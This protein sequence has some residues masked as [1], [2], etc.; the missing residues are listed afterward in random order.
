[1]EGHLSTAQH[2]DSE[3]KLEGRT[4]NS[5]PINIV[6]TINASTYTVPA[7]MNYYNSLAQQK[8]IPV[9]QPRVYLKPVHTH[10]P[11]PD[12]R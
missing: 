3:E 6:I 9:L 5:V 8:K 4:G 2:N 7:V 10:S 1:M 12:V 11:I